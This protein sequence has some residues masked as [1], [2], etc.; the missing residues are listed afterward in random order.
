MDYEAVKEQWSEV[1]DRD[2]VRLSWNVFPSSRMVIHLPYTNL[3]QADRSTGSFKAGC[4]DRRLI[5]SV[6]R[7]A[8]Y[9]SAAVR[10]RHMQAALSF[11][12]QPI[13]VNFP[14]PISSFRCPA[15]AP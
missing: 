15:H 13:L 4:T 9:A 3:A 12:P 6:E 1:E 2:G 14:W 8:R 10:A 11:G 7:E 5:Y